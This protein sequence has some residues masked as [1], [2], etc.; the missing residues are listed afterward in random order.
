[1][2]KREHACEPRL[3]IATL[4][5]SRMVESIFLVFRRA[6]IRLPAGP[7]L[8]G[9]ANRAIAQGGETAL[10]ARCRG[11]RLVGARGCVGCRRRRA[12]SRSAWV[13]GDA[14]CGHRGRGPP[15]PARCSDRLGVGDPAS[16]AVDPRTPEELRAVTPDPRGLHR[17]QQRVQA[18]ARRIVNQFRVV[19]DHRNAVAPR[20]AVSTGPILAKSAD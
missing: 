6:A 17:A 19:R 15:G 20:H 11:R 14:G 10:F 4:R 5:R 3:G 7:G 12:V 9:G 2:P 1:M 16:L 8:G 18:I 13:R